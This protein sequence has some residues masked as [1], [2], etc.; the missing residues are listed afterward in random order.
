MNS[1]EESKKLRT[2]PVR[3][4][5][6]S[7]VL[8]ALLAGCGTTKNYN[9]I[10]TGIP[11]KPAGYPIPLYTV[12]T[13]V[14]RPCDVIG[15]LAI[16]DTELTMRGGSLQ[17]EMK[18]LMD[19]AHEK[20]ADAVQL[21]VVEKPDFSSAHFRVQAN[22]LRYATAW[23]TE[24]L[25]EKDFLAYLRQHRQTLDPIEG[26]WDDGSPERLGIIRD[27][28]KPGRD[29]IAFTLNPG[30][31]SWHYGY[32]KMDIARLT[33]PGAYSLTYYRDDFV[34]VHSGLWLE[35]NRILNF[36]LPSGDSE[37]KISFGKIIAPLLAK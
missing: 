29:F 34:S 30:L 32:K 21:L 3:H 35:Q 28:S 14:P 19:T 25:S 5:M 12:D 2:G 27:A 17:A 20:G 33:R 15:Q 18:T 24:A 7:V 8:V 37:Y 22:L 31:A 1:S 36:N 26:I 16:G 9:P 4:L 10:M 6:L 23:E 13:P 11:P